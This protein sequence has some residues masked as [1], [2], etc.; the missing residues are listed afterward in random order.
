MSWMIYITARSAEAKGIKVFY[1]VESLAYPS[2]IP[3]LH[4][5]VAERSIH[6]E[7]YFLLFLATSE[8]GVE[9][10]TFTNREPS[11]HKQ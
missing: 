7:W 9:S 6:A 4:R 3:K 5:S 1:L 2:T 8:S 10:T 11:S